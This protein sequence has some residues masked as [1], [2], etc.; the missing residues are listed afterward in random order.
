VKKDI[1]TAT[2][3][4]ERERLAYAAARDAQADAVKAVQGKITAIYKTKGL[5]RSKKEENAAPLLKQKENIE[6]RYATEKAAFDQAAAALMPLEARR[7]ELT[8]QIGEQY[9]GARQMTNFD[10][11]TKTQ[12]EA[13]IDQD[14]VADG[15]TGNCAAPK[16]IAD[17]QSRGWIP[18]G[19]A[20][21]W[22]GKDLGTQ[23]DFGHSRAYVPSC[24]CCRAILGFALCGLAE[25][26]A[27]RA[28]VLD[29]QSEA[30]SRGVQGL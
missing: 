15:R 13:C 9:S 3:A 20:E 12:R 25:E 16:L 17:A 27:R 11:V 21:I 8:Q 19:I 26:Q 6:E 7:D 18:V 4:A 14:R 24:E 10:G 30:D 28:D 5:T 29:T 22:I 23:K 1:V 2:A